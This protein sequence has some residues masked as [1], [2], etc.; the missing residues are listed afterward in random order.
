M[1]LDIYFTKRKK[2]ADLDSFNK[3]CEEIDKFYSLPEDEFM[4]EGVQH[5]LDELE[6]KHAELNPRL[7]VANFHNVYFLDELFN[8]GDESKYKEITKNDVEELITRCERILD[9]K[10]EEKGKVIIDRNLAEELLP[11]CSRFGYNEEYIFNVGDVL[12][13]FT[14]ILNETDWDKEIIEM[15]CSW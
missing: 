9:T 8:Y 12:E 7:D 2:S 14:Y 13:Y 5:E 10:K 3:L 11:N 15:Y 4:Q 1:G 6:K